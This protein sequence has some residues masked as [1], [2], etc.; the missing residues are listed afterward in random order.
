MDVSRHTAPP[1]AP[2]MASANPSGLII[3]CSIC[4]LDL[5][6]RKAGLD[7]RMTPV[8]EKKIENPSALDI[9]LP[10]KNAI[11]KREPRG[12]RKFRIVASARGRY[13]NEPECAVSNM[14]NWD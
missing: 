7:T 4:P 5:E 2:S 1:K 12:A 9:L 3:P 8:K 14:C 13:C 10:L 6:S 11:A